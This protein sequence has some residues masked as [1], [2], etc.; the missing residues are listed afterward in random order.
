[1]ETLFFIIFFFVILFPLVLG[2][3][4][5]VYKNHY[6]VSGS[7]VNYDSSMSKFVY[8]IYMSRDEIINSLKMKNVKDELS[9]T[10]DFEK[11]TLLFSEYGSSREYFYEIEEYD[12]YSILKL[13]QVPL[14]GMR[15]HIPY[16]INPFLVSKI[17]AEIIPFSQY[18]F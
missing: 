2:I 8:K 3:I 12:G 7:I 5:P 14:I 1:M 10:F 9:C 11:S 17:N 15:S 13:N 6:K 4:I 16:K 18:S